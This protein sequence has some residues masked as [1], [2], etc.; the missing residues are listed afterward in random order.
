MISKVNIKLENIQATYLVNASNPWLRFGSGIDGALRIKGGWNYIDECITKSIEVVPIA[1]GDAVLMKTDSHLDCEYVIHAVAP[2]YSMKNYKALLRRLVKKIISLTPKRAT[3][4][5]PLLGSGAY[6]IPKKE[7]L[8][9]I[10]EVLK[11]YGKDRHFILSI[12]I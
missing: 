8:K 7:S 9:I 5:L 12:P 6:R 3:I 11:K 2:S 1:V 4:A 10:V